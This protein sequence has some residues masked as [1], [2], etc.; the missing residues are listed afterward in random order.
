MEGHFTLQ[1]KEEN[2][3]ENSIESTT[4]RKQKEIHGTL[5]EDIWRI[6][7]DFAA[8]QT[9]HRRKMVS[10]C[11]S[12]WDLLL[13]HQEIY[14]KEDLSQTHK[15][16][17]SA[18]WEEIGEAHKNMRDRMLVLCLQNINLWMK[19]WC[20]LEKHKAF[21]EEGRSENRKGMLST[22]AEDIL[23]IFK[24]LEANH[25]DFKVNLNRYKNISDL[26]TEVENLF[27]EEQCPW[28]NVADVLEKEKNLWK[29]GLDH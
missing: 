27:Q 8:T 14:K 11:E 29:E 2:D 3:W 24:N 22:L 6:Y 4:E 17:F 25:G 16:K 1:G 13:E 5:L 23:D 21:Q 7:K 15:E 10:F 12:V 28:K 9:D 19:T 18:L 26:L 20:V